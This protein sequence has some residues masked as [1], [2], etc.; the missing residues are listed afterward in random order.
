[1][2]R[3]SPVVVR[4]GLR[5]R[6][7]GP[8]ERTAIDGL[9]ARAE[10]ELR[11]YERAARRPGAIAAALAGWRHTVH[12]PV[13]E[14]LD[15][16]HSALPCCDPFEHRDELASALA[17]LHARTGREL[18]ARLDPLDAVLERRTRHD[19]A[20]PGHLPWWRRRG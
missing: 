5:R 7:E 18:R 8:A 14:L 20:T 17:A 12:L 3:R 4:A 10:R 13:K 15:E 16:M 19:P 2:T 1:M 6:S 11:A 9:S